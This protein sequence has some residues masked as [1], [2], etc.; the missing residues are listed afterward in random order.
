[1]KLCNYLQN[2][3]KALLAKYVKLNVPEHKKY[4]CQENTVDYKESIL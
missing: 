4:I 2:F 1:M 3:S